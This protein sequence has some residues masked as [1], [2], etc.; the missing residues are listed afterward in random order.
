MK[1]NQNLFPK[2]FCT[3]LILHLHLYICDSVWA[4]SRE[5]DSVALV[6]LYDS[7]NGPNWRVNTNWR[8]TN[9]INT[10]YGITLNAQGLVSSIHLY[11]DSL[12]GTL[13]PTFGV[14]NLTNLVDLLLYNNRLMGNIPHFNSPQLQTLRLYQNELTGSLPNFNLP[15]LQ[16]LDLWK[17]QFDSIP[18]FNQM[19]NL[20]YLWVNENHL[21]GN[22]PAFANL[23]QL[24]SIRLSDNQFTGSIPSFNLPFLQVCWLYKNQFD[25]LPS[26]SHLSSLNNLSVAGNQF[27]FD[28]ILPNLSVTGLSYN[29]QDSIYRD[30]TFSKTPGQSLVINLGID[31]ALTTNVYKWYKNGS[32]Y[33]TTSVNQLIFNSLSPTDAG[34]YT[35]QV[36]NPGAPLLTLY[37]RKITVQVSCAPVRDTAF[38]A[39]LCVGQRYRLPSGRTVNTLGNHRDTLKSISNTTCDSLRFAITLINDTGG[40]CGDSLALVELYDSTNGA[41]W[42]VNTNWRSANPINT[43]YGI[44]LDAQWRV[45][46]IRLSGDSLRGTLPPTFGVGNLLNLQSLVLYGNQLSGSIPNFNS[47]N[48]ESL[49]LTSNQLSGSIPNF[50]LPNLTDIDLSY[51][52]L[53]GIPNFNLPKLRYL[54]LTSNQLS[55]S[56]P[57]FNLTGLR[58][59]DLGK[60]QLN[61]IIPNFNWLPNLIALTLDHNQVS[62][63]LP[64]FNLQHLYQL[65]IDSTLIDSIP[66]LSAL[67]ILTTFKADTNRLTFDDILPNIRTGFTYWKQDSI[68]RD[69]T[70]SKLTGQSLNINLGI[71]GALTTNVYKWYKNGTLY[72]TTSVNQLIINSLV[73]SD[74]GLYTCEVTN[75]GAPLLTLYS[76]KITL[77]V[78]CKPA[79]DTAY[80]VP[81]CTGRTYTSPSGRTINAIGNYQDTIRSVLSPSCDSLRYALTVA[82]DNGCGC[83]DSLQLVALYRATG[84][85]TWTNNNFWLSTSSV[86]NWYGI[87]QDASGCVQQIDLN[88]NLL[89]GT[90]PNLTLS[91]LQSLNLSNN[92]IDSFATQSSSRLTTFNGAGNR[93]TFDD[94]LPNLPHNLRYAPQDSFYKDTAFTRNA[95]SALTIA[96]GIDGG[97]SNNVY[98]WYKNGVL[99]QTLSRNQLIFNMLKAS[100]PAVYTCRV[101]NPNAP[102][103]TLMSR[104]ITINVTCP[105]LQT[106]AQ[107]SI[108]QGYFHTLPSG[109][110]TTVGGTFRDTVPSW[111]GCDS[112]I[113]TTVTFLPTET[114][115]LPIEYDCTLTESKIETTLFMNRNG[116]DSNVIRTRIAAR[117]VVELPLKYLCEPNDTA[118]QIRRLTNQ[119]GC[120]SIVTQRFALAQSYNETVTKWVCSPAEIGVRTTRDTTFLGCDSIVTTRSVLARKDSFNFLIIECRIQDTGTIRKALTNQFGC[121]SIVIE[122]HRLVK[123]DTLVQSNVVCDTLFERMDT[124]LLKNRHHCDSLVIKHYVFDNCTCLKENNIYNGLIPNDDDNQNDYFNIS[125]IERY[126]PNELIITDKRGSIVYRTQNYRNTW[127]GTHQNGDPLPEGIY[128]YVFR[129]RHPITQKECLRMGAL[130]ITYI[131]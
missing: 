16:S 100:D 46:Y 47:P 117:N 64:T 32:L 105:A 99:W 38:T 127:S 104:K 95:G 6:A 74:A 54:W 15:Q 1:K 10:W 34:L 31:G 57:N 70:F 53:S 51:N 102:S 115:R 114:T 14:G 81:L 13:P 124:T 58:V 121:D 28:D 41:N 62:G 25:S 3:V 91:A 112:V 33:Q 90:L 59:L 130:T 110:I 19:P 55:G 85:T 63:T 113:H 29:P 89:N 96:L 87:T 30:T 2:W 23:T 86:Q 98:E 71:D 68:Y 111:L 50:N 26:L 116:C 40:R 73:L 84:G 12:K 131:P 17:N 61:G 22:L 101:T 77:Q 9:P 78:G 52:Q 21:K 118:T 44:T 94:I 56:I 72:Q 83:Q 128:D 82:N 125:F 35:C 11:D 36:T 93:V 43:W 80:T 107:V 42:R 65:S 67:A 69:T 45:Q 66:N 49:W 126:Q 129:T 122:R 88:N 123:K 18:D 20:Q 37:S 120:D 106:A 75:P 76:R 60:N 7:T 119:Y 109:R 5:Q 79:R 97:I 48:L 103:L 24:V 27:T 108:C 8:S 92:R 4:Q 39:S